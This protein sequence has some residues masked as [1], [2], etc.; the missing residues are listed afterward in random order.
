[1]GPLLGL[2]QVVLG[3]ADDDLL[4]EGDVL[5]QDVLQCQNLRLLL[6]V[7]QGQHDDGEIGLHGRL[8]EELVEH[9]LGVGVLFQLDDDTHSVAVGLVPDVGDAVQALVLHLFGHVLDELALVDLVWEL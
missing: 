6:V 7:H 1:M 9:H 8:S 5:V 4:L 3:P 2:S